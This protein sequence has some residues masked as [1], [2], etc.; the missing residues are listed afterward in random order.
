MRLTEWFTAQAKT[1]RSIDASLA[2]FKGQ[3][4][5]NDLVGR[6]ELALEDEFGGKAICAVICGDRG[7]DLEITTRIG[8]L[9]CR[10]KLLVGSAPQ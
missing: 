10:N 3:M 2:A 7:H 4:I 1:Q 6:I 5:D 8:Q 9:T